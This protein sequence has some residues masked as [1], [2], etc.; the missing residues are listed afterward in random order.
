M[1]YRIRFSFGPL[2]EANTKREALKL[3]LDTMRKTPEV[4]ISSVEYGELSKKPL[5]RRFL[6][7]R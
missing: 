4:F 6:S 3:V 1:L 7:D 5:W 2:I